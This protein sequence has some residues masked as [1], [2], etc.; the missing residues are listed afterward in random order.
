MPF[1]FVLL[2]A[3]V[4]P[5]TSPHVPKPDALALLTEVSHRYADAKSDHIEAVEES[6]SA[7]DLQHGW[8]KSLLT[9]VVA[10]GT[11][12]RYEGRSGYGAALVV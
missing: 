1:P 9:S 7:N 12:Y 6:S 3:L 5:Q 11:R 4:F 10:P 8:Q 2:L